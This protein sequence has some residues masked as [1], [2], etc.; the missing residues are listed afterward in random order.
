MDLPSGGETFTDRLGDP[1]RPLPAVDTL[2]GFYT[3][4]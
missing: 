1:I 2:P 4:L 3:T